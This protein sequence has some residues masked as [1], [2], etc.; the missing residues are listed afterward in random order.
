MTGALGAWLESELPGERL[1]ELRRLAGGH[2]NETYLLETSAGRRIL[3]RPPHA[4]IDASAH[5][6]VREYRVLC[7]LADTDVPAPRPLALCED[8]EVLG[9]SFMVMDFVDGVALTDRLPDSYPSDVRGAGYAVV[10]ALATLHR[11]PWR[12]LGLEGF[13]KPDGFLERQVGRWRSQFERYR[14]RELPLFDQLADWLE[15]NRPEESHAAIMHGDFHTDNC[16]I[17]RERPVVTAILDW[18]MATIGDPLIDLGLLLGFWG[19]QRPATPAMPHVQEFS[20]VAGAPSRDELA[21]RYAERSGI[22]IERLGYYLTLAF[23]KLAA[24]VEGAYAHY[25]SGDVDDDYSRD[26]AENVPRLLQEASEFTQ[27]GA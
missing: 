23:W 5:S 4:T 25:L 27:R 26:L 14:V 6:M 3:R 9:A 22:S 19:P 10:D 12:E 20:R 1:R 15:A 18:E 16:L 24:I 2:S 21:E 13:G 17:S 11:A 7:A 8:V